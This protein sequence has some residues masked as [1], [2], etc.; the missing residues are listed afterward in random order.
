MKRSNVDKA[1]D[2]MTG[3]NRN[4]PD[5]SSTFGACEN[6][7]CGNLARGCGYCADCHTEKLAEYVGDSVASHYHESVKLLK[8]MT[9]EMMDFI[10]EKE[11]KEDD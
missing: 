6:D 1:W 3:I 9:T 10:R 5:W 11:L 8:N 7:D 4:Y 2:H